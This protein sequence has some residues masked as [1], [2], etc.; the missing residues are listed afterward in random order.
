MY[1]FN[2]FDENNMTVISKCSTKSCMASIGVGIRI[3]KL[4]E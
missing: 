2:Y 4:N 3:S 1:N